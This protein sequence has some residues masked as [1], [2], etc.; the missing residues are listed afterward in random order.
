[1]PKGA[2]FTLGS[3]IDRNY[4]YALSTHHDY[5]ASPDFVTGMLKLFSCYKYYRLNLWS[6]LSYT[7]PH[8]EIHFVF[9]PN[10]ILNPFFVFARWVA[11][12]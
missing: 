1:M 6:T 3:G 9:Y 12:F 2:I 4:L 10:C 8:V 11:P 5:E 7:T